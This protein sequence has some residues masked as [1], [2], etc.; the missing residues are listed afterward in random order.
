MSLKRTREDPE[1]NVFESSSIEDRASKFVGLFSPDAPAKTLQAHAPY[2]DASHRILAWRKPSAQQSLMNLGATGK[3]LRPT[4]ATG[5]DDDGENYAGK[6]LE[7][8]L[9]DL[10]VVGAVVVARWYGGTLLGPVRFAHIEKVARE[11][12]GNWRKSLDNTA[13]SK[14][15]KMELSPQMTAEQETRQKTNLVQTLINRDSSI[16][17]LRSLLAEKNALAKGNASS[18]D[19]GTQAPSST[20]SATPDYSS[21]PLSKL[22]QLEKARD[23]T[24]SWILRQID[25]AE[26][27][28]VEESKPGESSGE[29]S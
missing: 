28:A 6:K 15:L 24:I 29:R 18:S 12:I 9:I 20:A 1:H 17:V 25:Q 19:K 22:Q 21:M 23:T 4:Y 11:A 3:T 27:R 7:K 14:R 16:K 13:S 26:A 2:K 10:D 5:H 8:L